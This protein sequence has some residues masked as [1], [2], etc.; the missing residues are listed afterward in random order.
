METYLRQLYLHSQRVNKKIS[1]SVT[2][3]HNLTTMPKVEQYVDNVLHFVPLPPSDSTLGFH[4]TGPIFFHRPGTR[5]LPLC[6]YSMRRLF[7]VFKPDAVIKLVTCALLEKQI[8]IRSTGTALCN[9]T[10][11]WSVDYEL[12]TLVGES[13]TNL[14]FPFQ[15]LHVY[16]PILPTTA[17]HCIEAPVPY[18]MGL[19]TDVDIS[20]SVSVCCPEIEKDQLFRV[21]V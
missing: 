9:L 14:I 10:I 16:V 8:V 15:W 7:A 6:E 5:G 11:Y 21:N 17:L 13:I 3:C 4:C 2:F 18:I 20:A 1:V 12:L 19:H